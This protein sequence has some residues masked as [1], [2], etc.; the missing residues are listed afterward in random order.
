MLQEQ[1]KTEQDL[2]VELAL[3]A[4]S[5]LKQS[6]GRSASYAALVVTTAG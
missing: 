1:H 5:S 4:P 3:N 2:A 6:A